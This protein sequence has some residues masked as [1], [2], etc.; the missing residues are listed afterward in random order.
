MSCPCIN[1]PYD[2]QGLWPWLR[3]RL[4]MVADRLGVSNDA[5]RERRLLFSQALKDYRD[6]I[7]RICFGYADSVQ[8]LEDLRQDAMLNLWESLPAYRGDCSLK[9][10]VYRVTLNSCVT[11][12][13]K[14]Y[15]RVKTVQLSALYDVIENDDNKALLEELH[16]AIAEL[17]PIDKA[18]VMLWLDETCYDEIAGIVGLTRANVATRLHRAKD[19][20]K[21]IIEK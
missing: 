16:A 18:I 13:R 2:N 12:L 15:R 7:D 14:S 20:L 5:G 9:S 19:K 17:N 1:L 21:S 10:W 3:S 4:L 6:L 8:S 11:A